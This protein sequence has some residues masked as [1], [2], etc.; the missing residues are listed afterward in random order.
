MSP[1]F[2]LSTR[3]NMLKHAGVKTIG[4]LA[5]ILT[6]LLASGYFP[7]SWR[8]V[9]VSM[10][11]KSGKN[12]RHAK[13]WRPISLSSCISKLF[14]CCIKE[15]LE[16]ERK[17]RKIKEN[18][19][20]AAYK[21]GRCCQEHILRLSEDVTH[22]FARQES[23]LAVFLDVSGAFNKVWIDG[24]IWKIMQMHLPLNLLNVI[25]GFLTNRSLRVRIGST[26]SPIIQMQAGTPQGAVLSP[27]L[28]NIFVDDLQD[29]LCSDNKI[30]LAQ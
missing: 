23:T 19:H 14:E 12:L 22:A 25:R 5:K 16:Q 20:Q 18:I 30:H 15:R 17:K 21:K 3:L 2:L 6:I 7:E 13:N 11:P 26:I 1:V 29:V 8:S 10:I 4:A 27:S 24:L 9:T 28:Y